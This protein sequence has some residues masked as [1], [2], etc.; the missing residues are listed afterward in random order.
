[1]R[2]NRNQDNGT[3][4]V[5]ELEI[6]SRKVETGYDERKKVEGT[7]NGKATEHQCEAQATGSKAIT[8]CPGFI[9]SCYEAE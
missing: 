2:Q 8:W 3:C 6:S 9:H 1:L 4:I 5:L 7:A